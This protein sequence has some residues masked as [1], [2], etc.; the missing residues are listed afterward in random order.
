MT[1]TQLVVELLVI[2]L[3]VAIWLA[4]IIL[5]ILKPSLSFDSLK[6]SAVMLIPVIGIMYVFGILLDRISYGL[7]RKVSSKIK[8]NVFNSEESG[9]VDDQERHILEASESLKSQII[10]NRSRFRICRSWVI[11]FLMIS[12]FFYIWN[13]RSGLLGNEKAIYISLILLS[14]SVAS[15]YVW[16]QLTRDHY[17]NIKYSYIHLNQVNS[18]DETNTPENRQDIRSSEVVGSDE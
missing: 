8:K 6:L 16:W 13:F 4:L 2:G 7:F 10:Y 1:T 3:G 9:K 5:A 18:F 15:Y 11:N 17:C 14:L 12:L